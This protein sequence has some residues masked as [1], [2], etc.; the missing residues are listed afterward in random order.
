MIKDNEFLKEISTKGLYSTDMRGKPMNVE[1]FY[2]AIS[3]I[4]KKS[5]QL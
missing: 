5:E 4:N 3:V 1:S 2:D